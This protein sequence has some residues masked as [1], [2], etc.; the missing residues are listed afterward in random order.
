MTNH[1]EPT[2]SEM[3]AQQGLVNRR[4]VRSIF[5]QKHSIYRGAEL[6]GRMT[7]KEAA[8]FCRKAA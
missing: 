8:E 7:A 4:D 5:D 2:I 3:L 1:K 6:I